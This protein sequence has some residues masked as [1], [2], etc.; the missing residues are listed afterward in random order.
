MIRFD[1]CQKGK[2][3]RE[4]RK[5]EPAIYQHFVSGHSSRLRLQIV[6]SVV[7]LVL[8]VLLCIIFSIEPGVIPFL[9]PILSIGCFVITQRVCE[10]RIKCQGCGK[11]LRFYCAKM[12]DT[13]R[14]IYRENSGNGDKPWDDKGWWKNKNAWECYF[15]DILECRT[16]DTYYYVRTHDGGG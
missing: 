12:G 13:D 8:V 4:S 6:L 16:C 3:N 9:A 5:L 1:P 15:A 14:K 7:T 2:V 10:G 11:K